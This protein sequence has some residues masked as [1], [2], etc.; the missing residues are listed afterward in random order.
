MLLVGHLLLL[1]PVLF[2]RVK[3]N[4]D[5]HQPARLTE[6]SATEVDQVEDTLDT[7][8]EHRLSGPTNEP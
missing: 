4:E 3:G 6:K 1:F 8:D 2:E 5:D 7:S